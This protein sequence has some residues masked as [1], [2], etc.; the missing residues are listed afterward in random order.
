MSPK[1]R[2][3]RIRL[4][5]P[6]HATIDDLR[7]SI[8]DI[9]AVGA[10]IEHTFPLHVGFE[11]T[12]KLTYEGV[13]VDVVSTVVRSRLDKSVSRDAIVYT[14]GLEFADGALGSEAVQDLIQEIVGM[15][16]DA[17]ATYAIER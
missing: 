7:V 5:A 9:S 17:R 11:L 15:D 8:I 1:R 12:L 4:Y 16:F 10:R 3:Q 6:L 2:A 14:T 13:S